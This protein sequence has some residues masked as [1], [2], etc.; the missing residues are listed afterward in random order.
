MKLSFAI[1]I[2][3]SFARNYPTLNGVINLD[4]QLVSESVQFKVTF[5]VV[6]IL[7]EGGAY[8]ENNPG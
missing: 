7:N 5:L 2:S 4:L 3:F 1:S 6:N 8:K